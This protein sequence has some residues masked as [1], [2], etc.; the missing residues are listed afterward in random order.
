LIVINAESHF[1]DHGLI[2]SIGFNSG[3]RPDFINDLPTARPLR[4]FVSLR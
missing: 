1:L 4:G 2:R 3:S